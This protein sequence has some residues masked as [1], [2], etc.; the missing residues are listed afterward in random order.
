MTPMTLQALGST[1]LLDVGRYGYAAL[2]AGVLLENAGVPVPGETMLLA[3][4]SLAARGRLSIFLV[5][6][7]AAA[8]AITGDNIGF[9]IGR[10][11]GR[12]FLERFGGWVLITPERLDRM[13]GFFRKRGP[14]AVF[15]ARFVPALRVVAALVAGSSSIHWLTFT[16][17]N[18]LGAL[19]WASGVSALGYFGTGAVASVLPW[20]R[21]AHLGVWG[22]ILASALALAGHAAFEAVH[23]RRMRTATKV[24]RRRKRRS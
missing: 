7:V 17:Y 10:L 16:I 22:L 2:G 18:A 13:D 1:L 12:P 5:A 24:R 8:A 9:A 14:V 11:G 6:L 19:A 15:G 20:L 21:G 23:E 4:A 3:A